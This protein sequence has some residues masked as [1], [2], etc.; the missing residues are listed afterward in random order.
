[1]TV[2]DLLV[3]VSDRHFRGGGERIKNISYDSPNNQR[4]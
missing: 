1:M 2:A 3:D 4:F